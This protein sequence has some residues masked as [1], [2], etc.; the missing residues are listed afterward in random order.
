MAAG[1]HAHRLGIVRTEMPSCRIVHCSLRVIY[2]SG[3]LADERHQHIVERLVNVALA[4]FHL[5]TTEHAL[6]VQDVRP[7]AAE[8]RWLVGAVE[9][10][11]EAIFCR[12]CSCPAV[13]RDH[14]LVVPVHKINLETLDTQ[15]GIVS[16][17][18]LHIPIERPVARP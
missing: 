17:N 7:S 13:E 18:I 12:S 5:F 14:H 10:D 15:R 1:T 3:A 2:R 16:A 11:Q 4:P 9:I 6:I 8:A